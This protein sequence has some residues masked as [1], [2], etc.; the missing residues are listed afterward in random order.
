MTPRFKLQPRLFMLSHSGR[1]LITQLQSVRQTQRTFCEYVVPRKIAWNLL[2]QQA[3]PLRQTQVES[4]LPLALPAQ[5]GVAA[6]LQA[7]PL[8]PA[9]SDTLYAL[10]DLELELIDPQGQVVQHKF[11]SC[12]QFRTFAAGR[13]EPQLLEFLATT[14]NFELSEWGWSCLRQGRCLVFEAYLLLAGWNLNIRK[15]TFAN[16]S[17][18]RC[19]GGMAEGMSSAGQ[20]QVCGR[21]AYVHWGP[22]LINGQTCQVIL[23]FGETETFAEAFVAELNQQLQGVAAVWTPSGHLLLMSQRPGEALNLARIPAPEVSPP[24]LQLELELPE[25]SFGTVQETA[26]MGEFELNGVSIVLASPSGEADV[27]WLCESIN[28]HSALTGVHAEVTAEQH[29]HLLSMHPQQPILVSTVSDSLQRALGLEPLRLGEQDFPA[30]QAA[31][32]R[33]TVLL[34]QV[35]GD[36]PAEL[37]QTQALLVALSAVPVLAGSLTNGQLQWEPQVLEHSLE[38][39]LGF[40]ETVMAAVE[41]CL[42]AP[43]TLSVHHLRPLQLDLEPAPLPARPLA[44]SETDQEPQ[45]RSTFDHKI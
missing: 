38:A 39:T 25:G 6:R 22:W 19:D 17:L 12:G 20:G 43:E 13:P 23:P 36:L 34:N 8:P 9:C 28:R 42:Q 33:W 24:D 4:L 41:Q 45:T 27:A 30:L 29:L 31:L 16:S 3:S 32:Q 1:H 21:L 44:E 40:L 14:L 5:A 37:P 18:P 10:P 2:Q 26:A 11:V 15:L 35:L 7:D